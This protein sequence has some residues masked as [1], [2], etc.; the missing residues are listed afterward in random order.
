MISLA[1]LRRFGPWL[2]GLF[3]TA[4]VAGMLPLATAHIQHVLES[5]RAI[6]AELAASGVVDRG[7]E[8]HGHHRHGAPDVNDQ[9]C[10]LHHHLAGVLPFASSIDRSNLLTAPIVPRPP[11]SLAAADPGLPERPPK[12]LLFV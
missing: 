11:R 8:Q 2:L 5:Q 9:C 12:L 10:T 4:Q 7:H 3:L 1:T 6:A